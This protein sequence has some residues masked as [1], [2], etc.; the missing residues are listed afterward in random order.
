MNRIQLVLLGLLG[1]NLLFAMELPF[2]TTPVKTDSN[3]IT[4]LL[5]IDP[6][7]QKTETLPT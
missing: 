4:N 2:S 3:L 1:I 7:D 5:R 6:D